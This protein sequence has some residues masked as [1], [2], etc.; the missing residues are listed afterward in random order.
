M[1]RVSN[2]S[3]EGALSQIIFTYSKT[4][5]KRVY[6]GW[7]PPAGGEKRRGKKILVEL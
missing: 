7:T 3:R 4:A 1:V 6:D 5:K 2:P